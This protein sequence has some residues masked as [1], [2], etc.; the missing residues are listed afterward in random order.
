[1]SASKYHCREE[2]SK[3]LNTINRIAEKS[4]LVGGR[5]ARLFCRGWRLGDDGKRN[6]VL[7]VFPAPEH[8]SPLILGRLAHEYD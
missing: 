2:R 1:M 5:R 3:L 8:R 4:G 7:V 6:A